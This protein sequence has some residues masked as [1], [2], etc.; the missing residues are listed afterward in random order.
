MAPPTR[1]EPVP[2]GPVADTAPIASSDGPHPRHTSQ[3]SADSSAFVPSTDAKS[4]A[5]GAG[6]PGQ[7][8]SL[9]SGS[10]SSVATLVS[11]QP[12]QAIVSTPGKPTG[13][14]SSPAHQPL[15]NLLSS[16]QSLVGR[17]TPLVTPFLHWTTYIATWQDRSVSL[18]ICLVWCLICLAPRFCIVY[19]PHAA[20]L[21]Y[22]GHE[23]SERAKSG[24][25]KK[26]PAVRL[27]PLP[28]LV[29]FLTNILSNLVARLSWL[30][31][32]QTI[33]ISYGAW[34]VINSIFP[35]G[36]IIMVSGLVV[37]G[38][39]SDLGEMV[40]EVARGRPVSNAA[41]AE[42][43]AGTVTHNE[44]AVAV[45]SLA[46][47]VTSTTRPNSGTEVGT[48]TIALNP[49]AIEGS[50]ESIEDDAA[51]EAEAEEAHR[52]AIFRAEQAALKAASEAQE[53]IRI[54][55]EAE[56]AAR[57]AN[58]AA[59]E[60]E[61]EAQKA[62]DDFVNVEMDAT[63]SG[64]GELNSDLE[65]SE[66]PQQ[67]DSLAVP[68]SAVADDR[69]SIASVSSEDPTV[70]AA[71]RLQTRLAEVAKKRLDEA[72]AAKQAASV[73]VERAA[74]TAAIVQ[75]VM[76]DDS[77]QV[78]P[79]KI[80][81][82]LLLSLSTSSDVPARTS[83]RLHSQQAARSSSTTPYSPNPPSP[84]PSNTAS[85]PEHPA[86]NFPQPSTTAPINYGVR[87]ES[88]SISQ[89]PRRVPSDGSM[90]LA[91]MDDVIAMA[92]S[93]QAKRSKE[94]LSY[95]KL[96]AEEFSAKAAMVARK[97]YGNLR[98]SDD[99]DDDA[100]SSVAASQGLRRTN[101]SKWS[102]SRSPQGDDDE[103]N[104]DEPSYS[105]SRGNPWDDDLASF[106]MQASEASDV[107]LDEAE[108][109]SIADNEMKTLDRYM[110]NWEA[111]ASGGPIVEPRSSSAAIPR[112]RSID[113]D[114]TTLERGSTLRRRLVSSQP[115]TNRMD[116]LQ[117]GST[118]P[119]QMRS[120]NPSPFATR[121]ERQAQNFQHQNPNSTFDP[122]F[123]N[124]PNYNATGLSSSTTQ[125]P[126]YVSPY[127]LAAAPPRKASE[128]SFRTAPVS[129]NKGGKTRSQSTDQQRT[130][131]T[132]HLSGEPCP[133]TYT[134][135]EKPRRGSS[136][137]RSSLRSR[138]RS[139][140]PLDVVLS[141]ECYENQRWWVGLGWVSHLLPAERPPWSDFGGSRSTPRESFELLPFRAEQLLAWKDEVP[142]DPS[143]RYS[144]EWD[145]PW[146]V[147]VSGGGQVGDVDEEGWAYADNL[148][149][150]WKNRKTLKRVVRHRRWVRH[151]RLFDLGL[152][153]SVK[154]SMRKQSSLLEMDDAGDA[155]EP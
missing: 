141:F 66:A 142:L 26:A 124:T 20:L 28:R 40:R 67:Q 12:P 72:L 117:T 2:A 27:P 39:F 34:I 58:L 137:S 105:R 15:S 134:P 111:Y 31:M 131:V 121:A 139:G 103:V 21:M 69:K 38:W 119:G 143:K 45:S 71:K 4:P 7:D 80:D 104:D 14:P 47:P 136:S 46:V 135:P 32:F 11:P 125:P 22:M 114:L 43:D 83:S 115:P 81:P 100:A 77:V 33:L 75:E 87:S 10:V 23:Y 30:Q 145:G 152:K 35:L 96:F 85:T 37:I 102:S 99:E 16:V 78:P 79:R 49:Q 91:S 29:R 129:P 18:A 74:E 50:L 36:V 138:K 13:P 62:E 70:I 9:R 84:V 110:S 86:A 25:P 60:A 107:V 68:A 48:A 154:F 113:S 123:G 63:T 148:W 19:G 133:L 82:L 140:I 92:G 130:P 108:E 5:G 53:A 112:R 55:A 93:L 146:Y 65:S 76:Q 101:A 98:L 1:T 97:P 90:S 57:A 155:M 144:W 126:P 120:V 153:Q 106:M 116:V 88:L 109:Q 127:A 149:K 6:S 122:Y 42:A 8:N 61:A 51:A 95:G 52:E 150:D 17:L 3:S 56:A 44:A 59:E 128:T 41:I 64:P 24:K 151:A 54:A 89:Q 147:D 73:A 132:P 94:G 118:A